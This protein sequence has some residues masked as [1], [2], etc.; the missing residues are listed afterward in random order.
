MNLL[1]RFNQK[2]QENLSKKKE[3][4]IFG[5]GDTIRVHVKI[6]EGDRE[7]VQKFEGI[8]IARKNAGLHSAFTVRRAS[9]GYGVERVFPLYSP[10]VK[11]IECVRRGK[12]RRAKIYYLRQLSGKKARILEK[13]TKIKK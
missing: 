5:P 7:R 6:S 13:R 11:Q 12:V 8:C 4:S 1:E 3:E 9:S 2:Q 10:K